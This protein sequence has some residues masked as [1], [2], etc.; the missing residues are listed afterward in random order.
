M[1]TLDLHDVRASLKLLRDTGDSALYENR[2]DT[3]CPV[4]DDRFDEV[5]ET[6]ER[7]RR[8]SPQRRIEFCLVNEGERVLIF[9]HA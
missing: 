9:T 8:F 5:L 6:T 3:C 7:S 4:C 2:D 1:P